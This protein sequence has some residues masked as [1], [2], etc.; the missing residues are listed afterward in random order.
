MSRV[1]S[2]LLTLRVT[3]GICFDKDELVAVR[4]WDVPSQGSPHHFTACGSSRDVIRIS[5]GVLDLLPVAG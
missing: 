1:K 5:W 2:S 3:F 4:P